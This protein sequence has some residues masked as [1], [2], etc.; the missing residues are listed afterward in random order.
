MLSAEGGAGADGDHSWNLRPGRRRAEGAQVRA[1]RPSRC[2]QS[3]R[4]EAADQLLCGLGWAAQR[5]AAK[6]R[7]RSIATPGRASR[8]GFD[9]FSRLL[10][11]LAPVQHCEGA[12]AGC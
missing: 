10:A 5:T 3:V 1:S 7:S 9:S 6:L 2:N 4:D 12:L 8:L 11:G